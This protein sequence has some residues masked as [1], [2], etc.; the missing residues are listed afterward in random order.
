[1]KVRVG[2]A[3][4]LQGCKIVDELEFDDGITDEELESEVREWALEKVEWWHERI[5]SA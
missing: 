5:T 4:G 2:V 1:M 3:M